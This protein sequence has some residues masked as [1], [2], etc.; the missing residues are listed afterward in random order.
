MTAESNGVTLSNGSRI[1]FA[2]A[3]TYNFQFSIQLTN[4]AVQIH[5][6]NVWLQRNGSIVADSNSQVSVPNS[7]GGTA[8]AIILALNYLITLNAGDYLELWWSTTDPSVMIE[9]IPA[10]TTPTVPEAPSIIVTAQ[11]VMYTQ[12]GPT[13][14]VGPTGPTG[15]AGA[16]GTSIGNGKV[17]ALSRG[18]A[19]V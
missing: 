15:A 18:F 8:G 12:V 4:S 9:T 5:D 14:A 6:A 16:T 11:Q 3:G 10:G 13:G 19:L 17:L 1:N 7:H 2:Y